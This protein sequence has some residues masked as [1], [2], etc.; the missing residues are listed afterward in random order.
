MSNCPSS[1]ANAKTEIK[2]TDKGVEVT[3]TA[4]EKADIDEIRA[5]AK[6]V[7]EHT[8]PPPP[9]AVKGG[10]TGKGG[11]GGSMGRCPVVLNDTTVVVAEVEKG[12][13]FTIE[14]KD[15]KELDWLRREA[16]ERLAELATGEKGD[17][18]MANCPSAVKGSTTAV[19]EAGGN[20]VV[21]VT[22]KDEAATKE[23]R[24][25]AKKLAAGKHDNSKKHEGDGSGAGGG[26]CP[27]LAEGAK[28]TFKDV[29]GGTEIT[30][31]PDKKDDAKKIFEEVTNRAKPFSG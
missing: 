11:A 31:T 28:S 5:R 25:R 24:E 26:D 17:R 16:K 21:T 8:K 19:K 10:H 3:V 1:V 12:S 27:A 7:E 6:K 23:I 13:K 9:D 29:D 15:V 2:D 30:I 14:P 4:S 18:K 22:S 20:V